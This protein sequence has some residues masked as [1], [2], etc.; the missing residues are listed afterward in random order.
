MAT[1]RIIVCVGASDE[2]TAH[3]RLLLRTAKIHLQ[4]IWS[5]GP[6]QKADLVVVDARHLIGD[7]ALR[8]TL[9]RGIACARLVEAGDPPVSGLQLRKP[10]NREDFVT[11]LN[12]IGQSSIAPLAIVPQGDDFFD[13]DLG[14]VNLGELESEFPGVTN[15]GKQRTEDDQEHEAFEEMFRRDPL[16]NIPQFLMP[17]K[18]AE[19]VGVE[20]IHASTSRSESRADATG[21]PFAREDYADALVDPSFRRDLEARSDDNATHSLVEYLA[22][23]LLGGPARITLPGVQPLVLDPKEHVF[24]AE[25]KLRALEPYVRTPL[26]YGDWQR[27]VNS[28][29]AALRQRV[30]AKPY[31]RLVWMERY[32]NSDGYLARHLDPGGTY[33]LTKWLELAVDYPRAFRVGANMINPLPLHE[34]ARFSEVG[35]AEVFDVVNAYEAIGY[36]EWAHRERKPRGGS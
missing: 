15:V 11:L 28:E 7:S 29:L 27:L 14:E 13:M 31:Q 33:R 19:D 10:L 8:R 5:W 24:H 4:A 26:R 18:L 34:I 32:I 3:L 20:Y 12:S 2:D 21:N 1:N 16:A 30:P 22:T 36:V 25:G 17:E 23:G 6:E 35:L 9:Q